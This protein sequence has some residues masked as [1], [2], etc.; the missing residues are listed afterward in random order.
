MSSKRPSTAHNRRRSCSAS[1]TSRST[2]YPNTPLKTSQTGSRKPVKV[3][4]LAQY[5]YSRSSRRQSVSKKCGLSPVY[6][7]PVRSVNPRSQF[8]MPSLSPTNDVSMQYNENS[9]NTDVITVNKTTQ[10]PIT[11]GTQTDVS[12]VSKNV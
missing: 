10:T 4:E 8:P 9:T 11:I 2:S 6:I 3:E 1:S 5:G 7:P 12:Y